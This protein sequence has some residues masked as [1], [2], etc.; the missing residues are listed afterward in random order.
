[1]Y[2]H[3]NLN[4]VVIDVTEDIRYVGRNATTGMKVLVRD[5]SEAIG[6]MG[7]DLVIRPLVSSALAPDF[8]TVEEAIPVSVIPEDYEPGKYTYNNG[9]FE[10]YEGV[11]PKDAEELTK[12]MNSLDKKVEEAVKAV[13][14]EWDPNGYS[15]FAGEKVSYKDSFYR[16]IQNHTSQS[17]WAPDV[18]VSLWVEM[19]DPS[20]EWPEWKQ[21]A[22]AHDAYNK[23]DKVS[24]NSKHWTSS[25]DSNVWEPGV[26]GW[27]ESELS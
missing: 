15:Y 11:I 1:M 6:V 23:G 9:K 17:D 25:V 22:G 24:H 5:K 19:S 4:R 10:F 26:Y 7:S 3:V 21:P 2:I 14:P 18:A 20:E 13:F 27:D 12:E 8:Y 16:C